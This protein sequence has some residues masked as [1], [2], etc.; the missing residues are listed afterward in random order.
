MYSFYIGRVSAIS[1]AE[2]NEITLTYYL[3][4]PNEISVDVFQFIRVNKGLV[5]ID[6]FFLLM[7][8]QYSHAEGSQKEGRNYQKQQFGID[9]CSY[10]KIHLT[11]FALL[12][13]FIG[14][15]IFILLAIRIF[16]KT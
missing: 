14:N 2:S 10:H 1:I 12:I 11:K 6:N 4:D 7:I 9:A 8:C 15:L 5:G 3:I 13:R 16:K